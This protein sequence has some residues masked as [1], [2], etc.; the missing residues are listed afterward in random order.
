MF[1]LVISNSFKKRRKVWN[2]EK[3]TQRLLKALTGFWRVIGF[4]ILSKD[5]KGLKPFQKY[6]NDLKIC[7]RGLLNSMLNPKGQN[8]SKRF[9][10][11]QKG[12]QK[13]QRGSKGSKRAEVGPNIQNNPSGSKMSLSLRA[14]NF[15]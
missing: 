1:L 4:I 2:D 3:L 12:S 6:P 7:H 11:C 15:H 8:G 10:S 14:P 9:Q 5:S 13:C